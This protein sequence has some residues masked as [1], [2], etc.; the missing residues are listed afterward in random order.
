MRAVRLFAR[1]GY[2]PSMLIGINGLALYLVES[3][4]PLWAAGALALPAIALTFLAERILPFRQAW[5]EPHADLGAD[6]AHGAVYELANLGAILLLPAIV[7]V[8]PWT[9][10]WPRHWPLWGQLAAAIA[11]A[12]V[13]LTLIHY[14]SHRVGW[15]W[16]LH[17]VHHGVARLYGFNGLV[18]HPLHQQLDLAV[19]TLPLVL[20][21][22][23]VDV[24]VL[25]G[26]AVTVQLVVQHSNV[27]YRLGPF[28]QLLAVGA[29]HRLHHVNWAADGD[30]NFGLF[31]T[32]WDRAL[33]TF[34]LGS[35]R[36]PAAGDIGIQ[37]QPGFPRPY[38]AQL[39]APFRRDRGG[40]AAG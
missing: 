11:I 17:C 37:D 24:A 8:L 9:G 5:N 19:G 18:R 26:L 7:S 12:D 20:A 14:A 36:A 39:T 31:L 28:Q 40:L 4:A 30:I 34:R 2:V 29:P 22:M 27:D 3:R 1:Y 21:G 23:P 15:L 25:L 33:G 32:L 35:Q 38:L 13:A 6:A 10:F 16:R